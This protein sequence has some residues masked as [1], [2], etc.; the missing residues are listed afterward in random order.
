MARG[1]ERVG[2]HVCGR[3]SARRPQL[4]SRDCWRSSCT[5]KPE[6]S[7]GSRRCR[8]SSRRFNARGLLSAGTQSHAHSAHRGPTVRVKRTGAEIVAG[9]PPAFPA[10]LFNKKVERMCRDK[11]E[12][13]PGTRQK[14]RSVGHPLHRLIQEKQSK[15]RSTQKSVPYYERGK[16]KQKQRDVIAD[17]ETLLQMRGEVPQQFRVC[18]HNRYFKKQSRNKSSQIIERRRRQR[19]RDVHLYHAGVLSS[20]IIASGSLHF[21]Y[22]LS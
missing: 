15:G 5:G 22:R 2:A 1:R 16:Q 18:D 13:S 10:M 17:S 7:S 20:W 21:A 9:G 4:H 8:S 12:S 11:M 19:L 14:S 3:S 6:R